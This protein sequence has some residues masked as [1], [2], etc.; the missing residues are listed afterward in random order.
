VHGQPTSI[1]FVSDFA[2]VPADHA[3]SALL[4][5]TDL[6][7][8]AQDANSDFRTLS[9]LCRFISS[10]NELQQA[11]ALRILLEAHQAFVLFRQRLI[12]SGNS[13][14]AAR[15]TKI[16]LS[17]TEH[18]TE[19]AFTLVSL[20]TYSQAL[21]TSGG[22]RYEVRDVESDNIL[23][24]LM[25]GC[26]EIVAAEGRIRKQLGVEAQAAV[27]VDQVIMPL[28]DAL[29]RAQGTDARG[30]VTQAGNAIE[31][32]LVELAGR[33]GISLVGRTGINSKIDAIK[34]GDV[35]KMPTKLSSVG[36]YLGHIRNAADH[37]IDAE[38]GAQW[39]IRESTGIEY[40][41]VACSFIVAAIALEQARQPEI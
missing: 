6:G 8:L 3:E 33:L 1:Q 12:V 41:F 30:A 21:S 15:Q 29:R 40:V 39:E 25:E 13:T 19:I 27:S 5:A 38:L 28:T 35:S 37:G 11:A 20:G 22:G 32:F 24:S 16:A 7:Y 9:P 26:G 17:L 14:D 31:S 23:A 18:H 2:D 10:A 4:L 34:A 36:K